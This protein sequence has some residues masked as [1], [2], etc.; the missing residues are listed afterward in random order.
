MQ[1]APMLFVLGCQLFTS[2]GQVHRELLVCGEVCQ[3]MLVVC[4]PLANGRIKSGH[5]KSVG[6]VRL[7]QDEDALHRLVLY[8]VVLVRAGQFEEGVVQLDREAPAGR[9]HSDAVEGGNGFCALVPAVAGELVYG[10]QEHLRGWCLLVRSGIPLV[11][12]GNI[13]RHLTQRVLSLGC[14][15]VWQELKH[16]LIFPMLHLHNVWQRDIEQGSPICVEL[17]RLVV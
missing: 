6:A 17:Q 14:S 1:L 5:H 7:G 4:L 9:Q 11:I 12:P 8:P 15:R 10:V 16:D 2:H 3:H 13:E